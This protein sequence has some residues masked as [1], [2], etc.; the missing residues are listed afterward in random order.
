MQDPGDPPFLALAWALL[1][2]ELLVIYEHEYL[3]IIQ[4]DGSFEIARVN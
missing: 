4:P 3:G 1:R 2:D